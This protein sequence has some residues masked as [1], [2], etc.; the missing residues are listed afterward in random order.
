M[1]GSDAPNPTEVTTPRSH[2]MLRGALT[3]KL[4]N[5]VGYSMYSRK[6][7]LAAMSNARESTRAVLVGY[8]SAK[9]NTAAPAG[10]AAIA[11]AAASKRA[12]F[13]P[14][15]FKAT[16]TSLVDAQ[17][18]VIPEARLDAKPL[19]QHP[20][21]KMTTTHCQWRLSIGAN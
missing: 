8:W 13:S 2:T 18:N 14:A 4:G 6:F 3:L 11:S 20:T 1:G 15:F 9:I 17:A 16:R 7:F 12:G 5:V 19:E 21:P 10:A